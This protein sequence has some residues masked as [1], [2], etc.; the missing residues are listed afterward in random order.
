MKNFEIFCE[1]LAEIADPSE[2]T[3][4]GV[5]YNLLDQIK[6]SQPVD[7]THISP[8]EEEKL[9]QTLERKKQMLRSHQQL[10]GNLVDGL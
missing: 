2:S 4:P 10:L 5:V 9:L 6:T 8:E 1:I 3:Y 7:V